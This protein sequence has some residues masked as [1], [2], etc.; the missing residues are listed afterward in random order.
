MLDTHIPYK[1][2]F[3]QCLLWAGIVLVVLAGVG[4]ADKQWQFLEAVARILLR[5]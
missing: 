2:E 3:T 5:S 1:K 4:I